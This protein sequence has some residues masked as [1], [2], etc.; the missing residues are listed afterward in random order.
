MRVTLDSS[1]VTVS[2]NDDSCMRG[3]CSSQQ[4]TKH[5]QPHNKDSAPS[6]ACVTAASSPELKSRVLSQA[7]SLTCLWL[8][9]KKFGPTPMLGAQPHKSTA[10]P[11]KT[12]GEEPANVAD[13]V[14]DRDREWAN[15][16]TPLLGTS[17][18]P[19]IHVTG[20]ANGRIASRSRSTSN[21]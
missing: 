7:I 10:D 20:P 21:C 16:T 19:R 13:D 4:D 14:F 5:H 18:L 6:N 3:E 1:R 12:I 11:E 8:W 2:T 15:E 17:G 9:E